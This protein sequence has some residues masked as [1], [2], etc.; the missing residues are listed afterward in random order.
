MQLHNNDGHVTV[1]IDVSFSDDENTIKDF[2]LMNNV[3][4]FKVK[5]KRA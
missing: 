3:H 5:K 4:L 1:I 2:V